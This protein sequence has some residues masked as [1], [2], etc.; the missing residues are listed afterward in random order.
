M[1]ASQVTYL[2]CLLQNCHPCTSLNWSSKLVHK[3]A[4]YQKKLF[5]K[6]KMDPVSIY[7]SE[8]NQNQ[9]E[10]KGKI[11]KYP[12]TS[13]HELAWWSRVVG[14]YPTTLEY[15]ISD[16]IVTS[17][18]MPRCG[19]QWGFWW[20]S[21]RFSAL[22][23]TKSVTHLHRWLPCGFFSSAVLGSTT[24]SSMTLAPWELSTQNTS[25]TISEGPK[26]KDGSH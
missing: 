12:F 5:F 16:I 11:S 6:L 17:Q 21:S 13:M 18:Q 8:D 23:L 14:N 7:S 20:F 25:S 19:S 1:L 9:L 15:T 24:W 22:E 4:L 10:E 3:I 26:R 2:G